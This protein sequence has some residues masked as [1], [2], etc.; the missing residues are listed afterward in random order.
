MDPKK[1]ERNLRDAS[2]DFDW[3]ICPLGYFPHD[4][5]IAW[6]SLLDNFS[7]YFHDFRNILLKPRTN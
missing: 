4:P 7:S 1:V 2:L 3:E 6:K 5:S